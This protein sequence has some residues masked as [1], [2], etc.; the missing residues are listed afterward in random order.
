MFPRFRAE[1]DPILIDPTFK[2]HELYMKKRAFEG[3]GRNPS[4]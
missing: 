1:S 2:W 4:Q 3:V